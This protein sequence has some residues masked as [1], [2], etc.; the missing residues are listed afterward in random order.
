MCYGSCFYEGYQG[1]CTLPPGETKSKCPEATGANIDPRLLKKR[2]KYNLKR[3]FEK[4]PKKYI[5]DKEKHIYFEV[6][7]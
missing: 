2:K 4:K 6:P 5:E 7:F 1:E 3:T